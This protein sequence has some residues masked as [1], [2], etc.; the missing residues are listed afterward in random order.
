MKTYRRSN[1]EI[2]PTRSSVKLIFASDA[3]CRHCQRN[4]GGL[5]VTLDKH[6]C[7]KC[8]FMRAYYLDKGKFVYTHS[9]AIL[10]SLGTTLLHCNSLTNIHN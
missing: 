3:K 8:D 6:S 1:E 7:V 5:L 4:V 9:N 10:V 2:R